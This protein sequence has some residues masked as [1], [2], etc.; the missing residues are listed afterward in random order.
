MSPSA[1][2]QKFLSAYLPSAQAQADWKYCNVLRD[3]LSA[4]GHAQAD[5]MSIFFV[6]V[7]I[8]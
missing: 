1:I 8:C 5:G 3:D 2:V 6:S 7:F 4:C